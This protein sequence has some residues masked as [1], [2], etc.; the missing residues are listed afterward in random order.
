M[1]SGKIFLAICALLAIA[2]G[3][4]EYAKYGNNGERRV[5]F[6]QRYNYH[7]KENNGRSRMDNR[8][9]RRSDKGADDDHDDVLD[10]INGLRNY[11]DSLVSR[12]LNSRLRSNGNIY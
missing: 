2:D 9:G 12:K 7:Q 8:N 5:A 10:N 11:I 3:Y 6:P 1:V 4:G